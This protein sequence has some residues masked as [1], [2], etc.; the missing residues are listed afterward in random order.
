MNDVKFLQI[1]D[2]LIRQSIQEHDLQRED[3]EVYSIKDLI[4]TPQLQ[5]Y[6]FKTNLASEKDSKKYHYVQIKVRNTSINHDII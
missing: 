3:E 6:I 1:H 4:E 5:D 2:S